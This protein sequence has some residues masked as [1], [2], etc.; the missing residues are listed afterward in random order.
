MIGTLKC[1]YPGLT[2]DAMA[3]IMDQIQKSIRQKVKRKLTP[4]VAN[5]WMLQ[6]DEMSW[7]DKSCVQLVVKRKDK[8][9]HLTFQ[10]DI[11]SNLQN[12]RLHARV[13]NIENDLEQRFI[14]G[15]LCLVRRQTSAFENIQIFGGLSN[16]SLKKVMNLLL[17][18][19]VSKMPGEDPWLGYVR[20]MKYYV[21]I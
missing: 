4:C 17:E 5:L 1:S 9:E 13:Y 10:V 20:M 12:N 3:G 11:K 18:W 19:W 7:L 15:F 16:R 21:Y 6:D 8:S 2:S 14:H